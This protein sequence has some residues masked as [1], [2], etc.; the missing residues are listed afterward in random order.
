[1]LPKGSFCSGDIESWKIII[2][3]DK[4]EGTAIINIPAKRAEG[5]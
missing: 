2:P 3:A 1:M 5:K 4:W